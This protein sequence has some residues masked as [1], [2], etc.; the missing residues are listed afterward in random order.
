MTSKVPDTETPVLVVGAGPAGLSAA[1]CLGRLGVSC[2]LAE[3]HPEVGR[4][5]RATGVRTRTMELLRSWKV[6]EPVRRR[7]LPGFGEFVWCNT[8]AGEELGRLIISPNETDMAYRRSISPTMVAFCPQDVVEP[9]LLEAV[10]RQSLVDLRMGTDVKGVEHGEDG[11]SAILVDSVEGQ[12][13]AVRA[14]YLLACDGASSGIRRALKIKMEGLDLALQFVSIYF[15]ADLTPWVGDTPAVLYWVINS[16]SSGALVT[17]D[18]R[19]RW[20]FTAIPRSTGTAISDEWCVETVREALGVPNLSIELLDARPWS[21]KAEVAERFRQRNIFLLGD[22]AHRFPP[23]GGF[24]MNSSIQDAHNLAWKIAAVYDGWATAGLLETY[25][26]ERRPVALF[27]SR[28]SAENMMFMAET[29][30]GPHVY[31]FGAGIERGGP[32]GEALRGQIREA[33]PKQVVQ[34]DALAQDIGFRYGGG[35]LVADCSAD[36]GSG[37]ALVDEFAAFVPD[38]APGSR[39]PHHVLTQNGSEI[40]TLD[41]FDERFVLLAAQGDNDGWVSAAVSAAAGRGVP[42]SAFSVGAGA[43]LGDST[44]SWA[45]TAGVGEAGAYLVRPDGHV[46][47]R[48]SQP[49]PADAAVVIDAV[50]GVVLGDAPATLQGA[51]ECVR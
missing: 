22:A 42:L 1:L 20:Y 18:G 34:F 47:W 36:R 3:R 37:G 19:D 12:E 28:R 8:I 6:D 13:Y 4:L 44:G 41:L 27:N 9:V 10:R 11:V 14:R 31:E 30:F 16:R 5:P 48:S 7:S 25:E 15:E 17:L 35:A 29:G 2:I 32:H 43:D 49:A 26:I 45:Q 24:G 50:L 38:A 51:G 23:T 39:A 46:A 40:S 33:I 21:M